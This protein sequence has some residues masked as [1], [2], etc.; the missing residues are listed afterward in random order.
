MSHDSRM[1][2]LVSFALLLQ[3]PF[4]FMVF[5]LIALN[6]I[7]SVICNGFLIVNVSDMILCPHCSL[8][9]IVV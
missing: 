9:I 8:L 3:I 5:L 6:E 2:D 4:P 7:L 1:R